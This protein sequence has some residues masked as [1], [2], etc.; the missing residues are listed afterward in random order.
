M[1][2]TLEYFLELQ[3]YNFDLHKRMDLNKNPEIAR[4]V[5]NSFVNSSEF[6]G[7][8][9]TE[10]VLS[11]KNAIDPLILYK[12]KDQV[13]NFI[14]QKINLNPIRKSTNDYLVAAEKSTNEFL[15]DYSEL[16]TKTPTVS[17]KDPFLN[18]ENFFD[19]AFNPT[20]IS[21]ITSYFKTIPTVT[22]AKIVKHFPN[23][24][25]SSVNDWHFDGPP[26]FI[27]SPK[28]LKAIYYLDDIKKVEEGPYCYV[29]ESHNDRLDFNNHTF[30][31]KKVIDYYGEDKIKYA[32]GDIGDVVIAKGEVLH[33]GQKPKNKSRTLLII[34]YCIHDESYKGKSNNNRINAF[35]TDI[36]SLKFSQLADCLNPVNK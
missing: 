27:G 6:L 28:M 19:V 14:D 12:I 15:T 22:F 26:G 5:R 35:Q 13:E 21:K 10:G 2:Q 32:F 9:E 4:Y 23:Q 17:I 16:E 30:S 7:E 8:L 33:K 25:L 31:N 11:I 3:R 36:N 34:N 18:V 20:V 1:E 24:K 29:K